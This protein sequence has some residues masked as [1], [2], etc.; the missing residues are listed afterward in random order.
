MSSHRLLCIYLCI[1]VSCIAVVDTLVS[2]PLDT[3]P[4]WTT[5]GQ[6]AFGVPTGNGGPESYDPASGHTGTN[7]FGYNL[8]GNYENDIPAY[9]LTTQAIDCRL[10]SNLK[11]SFWRW[12]G[13]EEFIFDEAKVQIS[14]DGAAW[15]P[16][17]VLR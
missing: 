4:G 1:I 14:N 3:N 10:G 16:V 7:V 9:S 5:E 6:W 17:L 8:N 15:F 12:L 2:F 13:V 11:L